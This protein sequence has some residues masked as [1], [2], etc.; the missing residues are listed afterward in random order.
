M[1][2]YVQYFINLDKDTCYNDDKI[3]CTKMIM[4][5]DMLYIVNGPIDDMVDKLESKLLQ[6]LD[7]HTPEITKT[8]TVRHRLPWYTDKIKEQKEEHVE[9]NKYG[10]NINCNP[11][12]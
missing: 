1:F 4:E 3:F 8:V 9:G 12:G 5:T 2:F 7:K 10:K 11:T 6:A